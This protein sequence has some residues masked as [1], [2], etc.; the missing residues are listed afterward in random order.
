MYREAAEPNRKAAESGD[1]EAMNNLAWLLAT[2]PISEVRDGRKAVAYAEKAVAATSRKESYYLGTL[3]AAYAETGEFAK[4]VAVLK[5]TIALL[6][7]EKI[8]QE[9]AGRLK[10]YESNKPYRE[11]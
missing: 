5:E 6:Q 2:C 11:E 3:G 7:D 8:R 10:L 1:V 9:F 4:A